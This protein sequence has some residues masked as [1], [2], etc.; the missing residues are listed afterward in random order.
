MN[1]LFSVTTLFFVGIVIFLTFLQMTEIMKQEE[2]AHKIVKG[3]FELSILTSD[4]LLHHENRAEKQWIS[5]HVSLTSLLSEIECQGPLKQS[6]LKNLREHH[7]RMKPL[8]FQLCENY[9]KRNLLSESTV[10]KQLEARLASQLLMISQQMVSDAFQFNTINRKDLVASHNRS[11]V[12]I[13]I[14]VLF[15]ATLIGVSSF[16]LR[17]SILGPLA[18]LQNST[19]IIGAGD[20][21]YRIASKAQDEIGQLA[22]AFDKMTGSRQQA[23]EALRVSEERYRTIFDH[24]AD[25]I[26]LIDAESGELVEFN[27]EAHESLGYTREE[28]EN[29]KTHDF[30]V[31]ESS[32]EIARRIEKVTKVGA[33]TF[34]TKHRTKAGEIRDIQVSSRAISI[35]G[36][37]F[38]HSIGR[39]I[40]ELKRTKDKIQ[41]SYDVQNVINT[42]L[43][44]SL[45]NIPLNE[46]LIGSVESILSIP[47][48]SFQSMGGI[49]LVEDDPEVLVLRTQN[50]HCQLFQKA[51][52]QVPF[53]RCLCGRAA[54]TQELQFA[55]SLND[56]HEIR[57]E[58]MQPH[59]DYCVPILSDGKTLGVLNIH[60]KHGHNC[61]QKEEEFLTVVANTL[62]GIIV[63]KRAEK[64]LETEKEKFQV[65]VEESP[66]GISLISK[67]GNYKYV[68]PKF[69]EMF[70]YTLEEIPTGRE[71]FRR[72][73]P[74]K[75]YR[76]QAIS[77]WITAIQEIKVGPTKTLLFAV[78]CKDGSK[79]EIQFLPVAMQNGEQFI[80]YEDIT[81]QKKTEARLIQSQKME[82]V[83][84]LAGGIAHDFNN[85]LTSIMGNAE[86]MLME[87]DENHPFHGNTQEIS[88]ASRRAAAL[89]RQLLAFSRKQVFH[90]KI[91]NLNEIVMSIKKMLKRLI[92]EDINLK[93]NLHPALRRVKMDTGQLEQVIVNLAVN[94]RDS[95]PDGGDLIIATEN[96]DLSQDYFRDHGMK[97]KPGP[98]V[99]L[100][101][102]DTGMGM[103][104]EVRSRVFEPFFTTKEVGKGTGLGLATVYG[105]VKQSNG[106]IFA[107]SQP[108]E[109]ATFELYL[110]KA[111]DD[112]KYAD[113]EKPSKAISTGS[114]T[115]LVVEDDNRVRNL[116]KKILMTTGYQVLEA[117]N[118]ESALEVSKGYKGTIH[119]MLTD[120]ILPGI[121]GLELAKMLEP[122]RPDMKVLYMTGYTDDSIAHYG[123][124]E[125]GIDLLDK[126]FSPEALSGKVR[127]VLDR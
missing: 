95:M 8:F 91:I 115:I 18:K 113:D 22:R 83:G 119:L 98:Y 94:A 36:K 58:G 40:T 32:E 61:D 70:G 53:G 51:C 15:L 89:T 4:Y 60:V 110:P 107:Q 79:K 82:A 118:S 38:V 101:V 65:L 124:P 35:Q 127:E 67:A 50:G 96:V 41:R 6:I 37:D 111:Q 78:T 62:A 29:I 109:G 74:D 48:F 92:K 84:T 25:S 33:D 12:V 120:V 103:G 45:E 56:R 3:V 43:N 49:F 88:L 52:S 114:G 123:V 16:L 20:L 2:A 47:W 105:I 76:N 102:R 55:D 125:S 10:Y 23:E 86:L 11:N 80:I 81:E 87:M 90:P 21:E 14:F 39:D 72:A 17:R 31:I 106:Y 64:A 75:E 104:E 85:L 100:R 28:F 69:V 30:E 116:V 19:E 54:L 73:Y 97:E 99:V 46:K 1:T 34:E 26:T 126:P 68:N 9:A 71:W 108:G 7:R 122:Q 121:N 44:L 24:A 93:S 66:L 59:G 117:Q 42:I 57:Y 112:I 5:K 77:A 13:M 63:R 27:E